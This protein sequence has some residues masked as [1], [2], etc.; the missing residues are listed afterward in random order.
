MGLDNPLHIAAVVVILLLLFGAKRVPTM[1]RDLGN[2]IREF[3]EGILNSSPVAASSP[4][5]PA[6]PLPAP[7]VAQ[8]PP[9]PVVE[10]QPAPQQVADPQST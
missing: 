10:A 3:K 8:A 5:E 4:P 7:I 9:Q 1:A 6:A 2:G